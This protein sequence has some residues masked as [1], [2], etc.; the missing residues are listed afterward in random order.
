MKEQNSRRDVF[1]QMILDAINSL[2]KKDMKDGYKMISKALIMEPD[3][4]E[5][6][7]L[8]GILAELKGDDSLACKHYR[9]AYALDPTYKPA[10]R[11]LERL[12]ISEWGLQSRDFAY[13]DEEETAIKKE[14][15]MYR[16]EE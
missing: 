16:T 3:A 11:N 6:H 1:S 14:Q 7:N 13:S 2:R 12:V 4:P 8:F 10:C 5:P 15:Q 9:A